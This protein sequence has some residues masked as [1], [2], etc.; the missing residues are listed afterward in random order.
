MAHKEV[1]R[2]EDSLAVLE[3][4]LMYMPD[5]LRSIAKLQ[6]APARYADIIRLMGTEQRLDGGA[7]WRGIPLVVNKRLTN[8]V[9]QLVLED[10]VPIEAV[11]A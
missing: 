4:A 5:D 10:I 2:V 9:I 7:R 1:H 11:E 3:V 8:D 6:A